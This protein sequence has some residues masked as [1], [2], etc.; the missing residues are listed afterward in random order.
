MNFYEWQVRGNKAR[1]GEEYRGLLLSST[2]DVKTNMDQT[3][4]SSFCWG[5]SSFLIV[6]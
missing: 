5:I 6:P 1:G 2:G 4:A 3:L